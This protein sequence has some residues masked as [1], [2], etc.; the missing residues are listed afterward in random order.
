M[1]FSFVGLRNVGLSLY[2]AS[3]PLGGVVLAR[4]WLLSCSLIR[5]FLVFNFFILLPLCVLVSSHHLVV[6]AVK[7]IFIFSLTRCSRCNFLFVGF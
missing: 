3:N 7:W 1:F 4:S 2:L 6:S 5:L